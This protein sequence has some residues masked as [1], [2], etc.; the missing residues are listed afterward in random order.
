MHFVIKQACMSNNPNPKT[1]FLPDL[2]ESGNTPSIPQKPVQRVRP[3]VAARVPEPRLGI[4][5]ETVTWKLVMYVG[6]D[7]ALPVNM[8][9]TGSILIGRS[10]SAQAFRPDFD[11]LPFG[12]Q[13]AGVSRRHALL[14]TSTNGLYLRD[15]GSTNGTRINGMRLE[16]NQSYRLHEG[17]DLELGQ[18]HMTLHMAR[19]AK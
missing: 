15:L 2:G 10:D 16:A 3:P 13:D 19:M 11:L 17:D 12:A 7:R 5:P 14:F 6:S 18:I 8:D 4:A 1:S 9:V